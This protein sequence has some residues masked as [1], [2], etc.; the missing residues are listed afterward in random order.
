MFDVNPKRL[1]IEPDD[2]GTDVGKGVDVGE[3]NF[4]ELIGA[5]KCVK[6]GT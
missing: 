6:C 5:S 3:D 4:N 1:I 2:D